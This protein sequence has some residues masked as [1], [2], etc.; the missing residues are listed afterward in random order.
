MVEGLTASGFFRWICLSVAKPVNYRVVS[1][2]IAFIILFGILSVFIDSITV[3]LFIASVIIELARLLKFDPVPLI[4]A[5]IFAANT[6]GAATM[7]GDP[8]NIIIGTTFGLTFSDFITHKGLIALAGL[9]LT[10]IFFLFVYLS[11]L[12]PEKNQKELYTAEK[13]SEPR[14][15]ISNLPSELPLMW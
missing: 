7:S 12:L 9:V 15:A 11:I 13:Y 14:E 10:L 4:I 2:F 8:P 5:V 3:L 1:I 6:G